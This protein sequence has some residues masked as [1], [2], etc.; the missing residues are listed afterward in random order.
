MQKKEPEI[1]I[2]AVGGWGEVGRNM[3]AVRVGD[4]AVIFDMGLHMPNYIKLT[5]EAEDIIKLDEPT[6]KRADA[7]PLDQSIR[8]LRLKVRAIVI[9]H[10][11]LDHIGAAPYTAQKYN[12]PIICTPFSAEVL[13]QLLRDQKIDLPNKIIPLKPGDSIPISS[14]LKIEFVRTTHSTVHTIIAALHTPRGA[15]I[16]GNDYKLDNHPLIGKPPDYERFT[17][18]GKKGVLCLIQDCIYAGDYRKTPSE[19]VAKNMLR[20][21]LLEV[22]SKGKGIIVTTFASHIARLK[23]IADFG[24]ILKRKVIFCGRS[25]A[26][27]S[28]AAKDAKIIDLEKN[29]EIMNYS[30]QTK[31]KLAE[32]QRK[33]KQ[34]YLL[35]V[36]GHQ[37]EPKS[38]LSKMLNG[39]YPWNFEGD[40]VIF[41]ASV[42]PA[43]IN[44]ANREVMDKALTQAGA[45]LFKDL[46]V[47]GHSSR[48]DMRE[49]INML[50]PKH[51]FPTHGDPSMMN[52]FNTLA[53]EMNYTMNETLHPLTNG[54]RQLL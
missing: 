4:E 39:T 35:V 21:V 3:T 44:R 12:A 5:E 51:L 17:Q 46:H 29:A 18:L 24:R 33:G 37:G 14:D 30:R 45:R 50:K 28:Y 43:D 22:G 27:Y 2:I 23:T 31:R 20:D 42:I 26:K 54:Q 36:T 13:K 25:I 16:Y 32:I 9:S 7:V 38:T 19:E 15:V 10:A 47:S 49:I 1:E 8:D 48:E 11:H 52:S 34:K 6:L 40:H 53:A 41:S